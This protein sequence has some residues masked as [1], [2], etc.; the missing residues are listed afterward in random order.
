MRICVISHAY[1]E[2]RYRHALDALAQQPGMTLGL[3]TPDRY[4]LGL[5][6]SSGDDAGSSALFQTYSLPVRWAQRQGTFLYRSQPLNKALDDFKPDVIL[7]EQE[8]YA[9]GAGQVARLASRRNVPLVM[10]LNENVHRALSLLRRWL[11][12][13]VLNR[14][15]G[16]IAVSKGSA[17]LHRDWGFT[18]P[19][20]VIAQ[21]GVPLEPM[22]KSGL[23]ASG[24]LSICFA[25]RLVPDKGVDC[26]LKAVALLHGEGTPVRCTIA[27]RG[28]SR[29]QLEA[30]TQN[31]GLTNSV[32]FAGVLMPDAVDE[33]LKESD[34]LVLPSRRT[35]VWEEQFGRVLIEAMTQGTVAVGTSTGAIGEVIASEQL[36]FAEDD[37]VGLADILR[38]L[39]TSESALKT[40]QQHCWKRVEEEYSSEAVAA[41]KRIFLNSILLAGTAPVATEQSV[42]I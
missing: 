27:G 8:V 42:V 19:I 6:T 35:K 5:Q 16:L 28:D 41:R 14:C 7:H 25:G 18:G 24:E 17:Q 1:H 2:A 20:R 34:V 32:R 38:C 22:P 23:R 31:L 29:A 33:M 15:D 21:M 37:H 11:R 13:F 40:Q 10:L 39:A 9:L 36:L 3:I 4:K 12:S 30:L 26:L